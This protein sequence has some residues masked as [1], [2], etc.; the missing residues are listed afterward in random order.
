MAGF[1]QGFGAAGQEPDARFLVFDFLGY[2][3]DHVL[4]PGDSFFRSRFDDGTFG[5]ETEG[6][7]GERSDFA[8]FRQ[9]LIVLEALEG[10]DGLGSPGAARIAAE[11]SAFGEG[12]L[13]F[14]VTLGRGLLLGPTAG[15]GGWFLGFAG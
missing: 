3:D 6:D 7:Q 12:L 8:V 13:Y 15:R 11:I 14:L 2:A 9:A 5:A 4:N 10:I 1:D